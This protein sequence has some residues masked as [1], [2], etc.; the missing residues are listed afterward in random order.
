MRRVIPP[1]SIWARKL[2]DESVRSGSGHKNLASSAVPRFGV[3]DS[4][5]HKSIGARWQDL[6]MGLLNRLL[7]RTPSG[8]GT[9]LARRLDDEPGSKRPPSKMRVES[10]EPELQGLVKLAGTTTF[11]NDAA[12]ALMGRHDQWEDGHLESDAFLQ[13]EADNEADPHAV[14]VHVEGQRVAYLPGYLAVRLPIES[15]EAQ[16]VKV[17]LFS[18]VTPKGLRV[19]GWAWLGSEPAQWQWS[20]SNRPPLNSRAKRVA[21]Q[22]ERSIMVRH[23]LAEG[24]RRAYEFDMGMV[25]GVHY[26]ELIEPIKQL[27][28]EGRYTE[29]LELCYAAIEG[30]ENGR[31]GREPAPW[32]TEQAAIVHRKLGERDKEIS[33]LERWVRVCPPERREGSSIQQRLNKLTGSI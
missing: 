17:Q 2:F 22:Q 4:E 1:R 15:G 9:A 23:A 6:L 16:P 10:A 14:A 31:E 26:L 20:A 29:A 24:G 12:A 13:R 11:A 8:E 5:I 33:V 7:K 3:G 28:R 18:E 21:E 32:Y 19:E 30:A 25:R 27:K